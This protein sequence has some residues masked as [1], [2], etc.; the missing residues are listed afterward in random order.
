MTSQQLVQETN[1][2]SLSPKLLVLW[3]SVFQIPFL[4]VIESSI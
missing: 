2:D 3:L 1:A 4:L